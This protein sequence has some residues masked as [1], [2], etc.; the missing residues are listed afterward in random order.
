MFERFLFSR[1]EVWLAAL[2]LLLAL[3]G[4]FFY[5]AFVKYASENRSAAGPLGAAALQVAGLPVDA[6][7]AVDQMFEGHKSALHAYEQ[8]FGTETGFH[9]AYPAGSRPGAG[10]LL[11]SRYDGDAGQSVVEL[12]DLN[13]QT[14]L[15]RWAPDFDA[16][17][18]QFK[19]DAALPDSNWADPAERV[20][21]IHPLPTPD[22]GLIYQN[23]SPLVK[24]DACAKPVWVVNGIYHHSAERA[25]DGSLWVP[26]YHVPSQLPLVDSQFQEDEIVHLS[27]E[28][29][30]LSRTS[31]VKLL[32]DNGYGHLVFGNAEYVNDATHLNDIQP[33][34]GD[35]PY[36]K[37]GD[38]FLSLRNISTVLLYRPSENR[39]VW[40]KQ[41][42]WV[43]QHDVDVLDDHRIS[44]FDNRKFNFRDHRSKVVPFND[45]KIYDFATD[46]VSSPWQEAMAKLELRTVDM[47]RQEV[48]DADT[49]FVEESNF[50]RL[51]QLHRDAG[52][53]WQYL[54]RSGDGT[55][56]LLNWTRLLDRA[57]GDAFAA[58]V[59]AA[60]AG[61]EG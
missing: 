43:N 48:I 33:V 53:D 49:V 11:L 36:W 60:A 55:A 45:V 46:T 54:N 29:E 20:R 3:L 22:G 32:Q 26:F 24:I 23:D 61:C 15:H 37:A 34:P 42:P 2:L 31:V 9:F 6:K 14:I 58:A 59:A 4:A 13:R 17:R 12:V 57:E 1:I 18:R 19:V 27:A 41:W 28:G 51:V 7:N 56:Y 35:G 50:G 40:L 8:R 30:V 38:V 39:V 47:G 44:I 25:P 52:V 21:L 5:G 10:Y 16:I